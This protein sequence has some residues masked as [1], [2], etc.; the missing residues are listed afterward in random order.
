MKNIGVVGA[1]LIM[2]VGAILMMV[3]GANL[4]ICI[5]NLENHRDKSREEN[6][7]LPQC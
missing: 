6:K 7:L 4:I 5:S 1:F 3:V 2:V